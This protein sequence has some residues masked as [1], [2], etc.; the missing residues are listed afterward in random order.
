MFSTILIENNLNKNTVK[1]DPRR[2]QKFFRRKKKS[3]EQRKYCKMGEI[4]HRNKDFFFPF[5][6]F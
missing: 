6:V 2:R 4:F 5:S 1:H 3:H